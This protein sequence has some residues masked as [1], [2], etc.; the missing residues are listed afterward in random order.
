M[1]S[2]PASPDL[3]FGE[4]AKQRLEAEDSALPWKETEDEHVHGGSDL[5][6]RGCGL[7]RGGAGV[8]GLS[9]EKA[10]PGC[11]GGELPEPGLSRR[12]QSK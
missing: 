1:R 3:S 11:D 5:Q 7:H 10:V 2:G 12:K 4:K 9:P 8:T 6:G